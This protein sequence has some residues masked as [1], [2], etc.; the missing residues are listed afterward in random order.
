MPNLVLASASPRRRALLEA[1]GLAV[2]V[3]VADIAE[4]SWPGEEPVACARRLAEAKA[5][6]VAAGIPA[7]RVVLGADTV[8]HA[9]G[10]LWGKP[11]DAVDAERTLGALSGRWHAVTTG[12]CAVLGDRVH[13][14][15]VTTRVS[16]RRLTRA[17]I[18]RYVASGEP[19]DKAGAYGI[20]GLGSALVDRVEGSWSNVVGLPVAEVLAVLAGL[21]AV[22]EGE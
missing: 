13:T 8:V 19:L 15:H 2:E 20:Q 7:D 5:L 22:P 10:V 21:G 3:R 16:F 9:E 4:D 14:G 11:V 6:A 18:R 12:Y 1:A 17:E